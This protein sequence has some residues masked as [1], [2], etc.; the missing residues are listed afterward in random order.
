VDV[1][2]PAEVNFK[3]TTGSYVGDDAD[4]KAIPH[5]LGVA[6][7]IVL[8]TNISYNGWVAGIDAVNLETGT[9]QAVTT[10]DATNFRV[11]KTG[12]NFNNSGNTYVWVAIAAW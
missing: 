1:S 10:A 7:V 3:I 8:I 5:S 12:V 4:D 6:P 9:R 2:N 11:S